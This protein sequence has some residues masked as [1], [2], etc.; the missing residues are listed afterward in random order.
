MKREIMKKIKTLFT[1]LLITLSTLPVYSQK[2]EEYSEFKA[3]NLDL[4]YGS[5][6]LGA[7]AGFRYSF[8]SLTVGIAGFANDIPNYASIPPQGVIITPH[9]P[10]PTGY[11]E[12][13]YE[14]L[15][16]TVDLAYNYDIEDF[17]IYG[18]LGYFTAQ[19]SVLAKNI[20]TNDRYSYKVENSSG[21]S[22]G[23]GGYYSLNEWICLGL[24]YNTK[25]GIFGQFVYTW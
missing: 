6:G 7:A 14:A 25:R 17:T 5:Y 8:L 10:L 20:N 12:D 24:G 11:V 13:K 9:Q 23:L 4:G 22:V 16:F 18:S 21:I 19:D 3:I 15:M 2:A 1:L